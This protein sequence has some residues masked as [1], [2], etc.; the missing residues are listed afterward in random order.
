MKRKRIFAVFCTILL[1]A[2]ITVGIG[3]MFGSAAAGAANLA[4]PVASG[5]LVYENE[6]AS[7]D[8]SNASGGYFMV[9]YLESTT[10]R[11]RIV[12]QCPSGLK[13]SY[14]LN[15]SGNYETFPFSD[16]NGTYKITV[17]KNTSGNK[18]STSFSA[19]VD[20]ALKD[21]FAP[22]L[23]PNQYVNY[24]PDSKVVAKGKELTSGCT[25][26]IDC[27]KAVYSYVVEN[28]TYDHDRAENVSS[29]YLPV[30]DS[31]LAEKKGIC[32]D[33]ASVMTAMLRS[34][35][36]PCKLVVGY[37]G[38]TYHAWIN[39][40]SE[41]DGWINSAIY[42]DGT[43]WKLMDPTFASSAKESDAIMKYIGDGENYSPKY[44]Y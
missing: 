37:A 20:V 17:Y 10:S 2:S 43:T 44:L 28:F 26:L 29:G 30:L 9:K 35:G 42:F 13:Y 38:K 31:V 15:N 25:E 39:V 41:K 22:F 5:T 24:T 18:Y 40:Y 34:Q 1:I 23:L 33:Y 4:M 27:I 8:A 36:I 32:F 6:K 7:I 12:V 21:E 11:I 19:S 3:G 16:G 14:N